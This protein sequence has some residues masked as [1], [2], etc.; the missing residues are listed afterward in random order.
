MAQWDVYAN[1]S[2]RARMELPFLVDVQCD[3]LAV[4]T[5][6]LVIPC[7]P[8]EAAAGG[9]PPRMSPAFEVDGMT[10]VLLPQEAGPV[11]VAALRR[12]VASLREQSHRIIDALDAVVSGI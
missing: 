5:T 7:A 3:L 10:V 8:A 9:L 6:R 4:L 1:P 2:P 11:P 12:P